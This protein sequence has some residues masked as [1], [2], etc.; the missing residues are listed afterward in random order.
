[1]Q[2]SH[3]IWFCVQIMEIRGEVEDAHF[4]K[5]VC[6]KCAEKRK[7][8]QVRYCQPCGAAS[9]GWS[10]KR[11]GMESI[12]LLCNVKRKLSC[13]LGSGFSHSL[14]VWA[15]VNFS[16]KGKILQM[17]KS[18]TCAIALSVDGSGLSVLF[19]V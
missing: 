17:R 13:S 5:P 7:M 8:L 18:K 4:S 14:Y 9:H 19:F 10:I 16:A 15:W 12:F 1:M 11:L 3:L 2:A 6:S